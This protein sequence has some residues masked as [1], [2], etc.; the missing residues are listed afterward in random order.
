MTPADTA[1]T[2]GHARAPGRPRDQVAHDAIQDA[3]MSL[4]GECCYSEITIE[5]I[6]ARAGVGKPTIYR[7]WKTKADVVIDAYAASASSKSVPTIP[8]EDVFDDLVRFLERIF[9]VN[10]HPL[11]MRALRCF[12]AEAQYDEQFRAKFYELMLSQRR[13]ALGKL[14]DHGKAMGQIRPDINNEIVA[15][16]VYGAFATRIITD[17]GRLDRIF[18]EQI[19]AT[20]RGG[21]EA[22]TR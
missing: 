14:L 12:I 15:D 8:S 19:I 16:L 13:V 18:A 21:I 9:I 2:L 11:N 10:S 5:K 22:K 4:L 3:A 6:A 17:H 20:L 7:R 1:D